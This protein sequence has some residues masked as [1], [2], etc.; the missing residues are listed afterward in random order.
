MELI[1]ITGWLVAA[2][3]FV[4]AILYHQEY[5]YHEGQS[6]YYHELYHLRVCDINNLREQ[7]GA[8]TDKLDIAVRE[9]DIWQERAVRL[10]LAWSKLKKDSEASHKKA[11]G[12]WEI[13]TCTIP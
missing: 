5:K 8:V 4:F 7:L 2:I 10:T 6:D 9:C 13:G 12:E 11:L 3:V 1:A